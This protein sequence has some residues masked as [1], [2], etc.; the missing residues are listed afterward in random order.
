MGGRMPGGRKGG[1]PGKGG[2]EGGWPPGAPLGC[3]CIWAAPGP[4]TP[5]TGPASPTG[6]AE[7]P[8]TP[9]GVS[10]RPAA[11]PAPTHEDKRIGQVMKRNHVPPRLCKYMKIAE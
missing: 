8:G 4:P 1:T 10:P 5:R 7:A 3:G 9:A 6:A 2:T 11:R